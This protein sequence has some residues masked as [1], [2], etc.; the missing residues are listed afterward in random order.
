MYNKKVVSLVLIA[1]GLFFLA[2]CGSSDKAV[3][4]PIINDG[5]VIEETTN[6]M[7][8]SKEQ[9]ID[10]MAYA[11]KVVELQT[12]WDTESAM[13]WA[14]KAADLQEWY[15]SDDAAY[16]EKCGN[17]ALSDPNIMQKAQERA[18]ELK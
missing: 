1:A 14:Q 4:E 18:L 17:Y 7:T 15:I 10:V 8:I 13:V 9:C 2:G 3:Q 16:E 5:T 12:K 6:E 11:L